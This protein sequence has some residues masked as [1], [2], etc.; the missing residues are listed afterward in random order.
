MQLPTREIH[1]LKLGEHMT[2]VRKV[3]ISFWVVGFFISG[4]FAQDSWLHLE[5]T[6]SGVLQLTWPSLTGNATLEETEDLLNWKLH[7]G[8]PVLDGSIYTL[9]VEPQEQVRFFRVHWTSGLDL[10]GQD[11]V[12]PLLPTATVADF[13]SATSFL[14]EGT[15]AVQTGVVANA[16][17]PV[18][19]GVVRGSVRDS[20]GRPLTGVKVSVEGHPEYGGTI[21]RTNGQFDLAVNGGGT[22]AVNYEKPGYLPAQRQIFVPWQGMTTTVEVN[23]VAL[24]P[25]L[26][27]V[28]LGV[29][30]TPQVA[31]GSAQND[32]DGFRQATLLLPAG[33]SAITFTPDGSTQTVA[34]LS[35]RATEYT[36]GPSGPK[37]MPAA[38]PP[39][40]A[41]TYCVEL[42]ADELP[43]D[44]T[45]Q[46]DRPVPFYVEN[47][48]G[49]PVGV[50]VPVGVFDKAKRNWRAEP[51][52]RVIR[53]LD[54]QNDK[55]TID[56]TGRGPAG[57]TDLAAL[58]I[59]DTELA[60]LALLYP[61]GA[62]VW[63]AQVRHFSTYDLNYGTVPRDGATKPQVESAQGDEPIDSKRNAKKDGYGTLEAQNRNFREVISLPG[64]SF[65]LHYSSDRM[66]GRVA[67][68]TL[69]I[70]LSGSSLPGVLKAIKLE[71]S[72]AGRKMQLDFPPQTN[73]VYTFVWD[74]LDVYGRPLQGAQPVDYRV[75]YVYD[76]Y[77]ALPPS[78][79]ASFGAASGTKLPGDVKAREDAILW[80]DA[81]AY[82]GGWYAAGQKL[83]G[84]TLNILHA[85]DP[86][87]RN[88]YLGNGT[89]RRAEEWRIVKPLV[90]TGSAGFSG[91]GGFASQAK[92]NGPAGITIAP[93]GT[94]FFTDEFN[95][96]IRRIGT[97]GVVTTY[98]GGG[99][100]AA[101]G[102]NRL[103]ARLERPV[104]I[105][106]APD[107]TIFFTQKYHRVRKVTPDGRVLTIAG[108]GVGGYRGDGG[109]SVNARVYFPQ[110]CLLGPDGGLY[111]TDWYN[112]RIRRIG[113]EGNITTVAGTG[114]AGFSGDGGPAIQARI[115]NPTGG[116]DIAP[117]GTV[118]FTDTGN[119]R[120]RKVTPDGIISTIAGT[121]TTGFSG[122]GG[123]SNLAQVKGV[124]GIMFGRDGII[125]IADNGN[126]RIR[127]IDRRG[128]IMTIAGNGATRNLL[129]EGY[130]GQATVSPGGMRQGPD[131]T[132]YNA[133]WN[134]HIIRKIYPPLPGYNATDTAI[135][136]EDGAEVYI[137]SSNGLHLKTV[138]GLTGATLYRFVYDD[139]G[140]LT[141]LID[142]DERVTRFER[143]ADEQLAAVVAPGGQ[144]TR[145]R[146]NAG[147]FLAEAVNPANETNRFAYASGGLLTA[148]TGNDGAAYSIAYDTL[149]R[150][151]RVSDPMGGFTEL[152]EMESP[153]SRSIVQVSAE[154]RRKSFSV[155]KT[156]ARQHKLDV[157]TDGRPMETFINNDGTI[158]NILSDGT[159]IAT[160]QGPDSRFG[161]LTPVNVFQVVRTP[162][163]RVSQTTTERSSL[164]SAPSDL[165]SVVSTTTRVSYNG[166][167]F[168]SVY[169]AS[170]QTVT[171]TSPANRK[172]TSR[173]DS[174]GR[175]LEER[176]GTQEPH[177]VL[178]ATNG[179]VIARTTGQG[180]DARSTTYGYDSRG[181]M[182]SATNAIGQVTKWNRD[183]M[184]RP[185]EQILPSG[186][187][188][189]YGYDS[190]GRLSFLTPP[191]KAP[192]GMEYNAA[193][194]GA[195]YEP[196]AVDGS[197]MAIAYFYNKDRQLTQTRRGD[198][199]WVQYDYDQAGRHT[200]TTSSLGEGLFNTYSNGALVAVTLSNG[201]MLSLKYDGRLL[202][203]EAWSGVVTAKVSR[204]YDSS[205]RIVS[206]SL[207]DQMVTDY[208]F[209]PDSLITRAG[210]MNFVRDA[211]NGL[212]RS[213]ELNNL[214]IEWDYNTF[215]ELTNQTVR[216]QGQVLAHYSYLRDKLGRLIA[217]TEAFDTTT[218]DWSYKYDA[219]NRL[220]RV[221]RDGVETATYQY[222]ANGNRT[223]C[224]RGNVEFAGIYDAQDRLLRHGS[225]NYEYNPLGELIRVSDALGDQA[226]TYDMA[227]NLRTSTQVGNL[228]EYVCDGL[229]R[230]CAVKRNGA[231][232]KAFVYQDARR[233]L[234]EFDA[235]GSV[236]SVFI[237]ALNSDLPNYMAQG[238]TNYLIVGDHLGSARLVIDA[239]S[240]SVVQRLEFDEFGRTIEDTNPGFQPFG[241]AG[242]LKDNVSG[243]AHFGAREYD[244]DTGRFTSKD[245]ARFAGGSLNVYTYALN[246]PASLSDPTGFGAN[247]DPY[248]GKLLNPD[249]LLKQAN[250]LLKKP[251]R[252]NLREQLKKPP[253]SQ[254]DIDFAEK[255]IAMYEKEIQSLVGGTTISPE[256][257]DG[258]SVGGYVVVQNT[259]GA[260]PDWTNP[261]N[262]QI[263]DAAQ[264]GGTSLLELYDPT[265]KIQRLEIQK[266]I[267]EDFIHEAKVQLGA[268]ERV[269]TDLGL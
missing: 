190:G 8:N 131:G 201:P 182:T 197:S 224:H 123:P 205:F 216:L 212:P 169:T 210:E 268:Y 64:T 75:G 90:G 73:L 267:Y 132:I 133:E 266:K 171:T 256:M 10:P 137:F 128:I 200:V 54:I 63:R 81:V 60:R 136:S 188:V 127:T 97:D 51:D 147:G 126:G 165:F 214:N 193:G 241:F 88:L 151:V 55:A 163:G 106:L 152:T 104:G 227:G 21:T 70:P 196:P 226:F 192:H 18:Q 219:A 47:F 225:A 251:I 217:K 164:L 93:D 49:I 149:G 56:V 124:S 246:S 239:V 78:M 148:V 71:I 72:V 115:S 14:Y 1:K 231:L 22:V 13:R 248:A 85:F 254:K 114:T 36:V 103:D 87:S 173:F 26:T 52:G 67:V 242:G 76:A 179:L 24:D 238:G 68:N 155:G 134:N 105:E 185:V 209:D 175:L 31:R 263:C 41:Y 191:G 130:I 89:T 168:T 100:N 11:L 252:E 159:V 102:A 7:L 113:P 121:G 3:I 9:T 84:W 42:T 35:I 101:E 12:A 244:P 202:M 253:F 50:A 135:P 43:Q 250:D 32:G 4:S 6:T 187:S 180:P 249:D 5:R 158:T 53:I 262:R 234:A 38:L 265:V 228:L 229:N 236:R 2:K 174:R 82:V 259:G 57:P 257:E 177:T 230:R 33:T 144:T 172:T 27:V 176:V 218:H 94:A 16:I 221:I 220:A 139:Q 80:Q 183:D 141:Y 96:R 111:I 86:M 269:K 29:D 25:V 167:V 28:Q 98:A 160:S 157:N 125:Y 143:S 34:S 92:V 120:F 119:E 39:T 247:W 17:Q 110:S 184:G 208:S 223:S 74:G 178:Y 204:A 206:Y 44:A 116:L 69:E 195:K 161:P 79:A 65:S 156:P 154:G 108:D 91:D 240:G 109:P 222:D 162:E 77:Y 117:D 83:G 170:N 107:G 189:A 46:F 15:Q 166:R 129:P 153:E 95:H 233:V 40:S 243:L 37:K 235:A 260:E 258:D 23:L 186:V 112:H 198:S 255:Q 19:A 30:T 264:G 213:C 59:D 232:S 150:A 140:R 48:L 181:W 142:G 199:S 237:H 215:G 138:Y 194:L 99:S 45:L 245:P 66:P 211:E 62:S 61:V 261:V 118:F 203:D 20:S 145:F 146:V 58:G 207:N 122:D